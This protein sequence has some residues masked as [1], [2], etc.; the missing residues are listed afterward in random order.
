MTK[1]TEPWPIPTKALGSKGRAA[2]EAILAFLQ[3]KNLTDHGGGGKFYGP[4]EWENR[5]E[6]YGLGALLIVTHD[7][8]DHAPA[9]NWDYE[10]YDLVEDLRLALQKIGVYVEQCTSWYSAIYPIRP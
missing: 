2:A 7:G 1:T 9:F 6:S 8:G 3:E 5:G 10:A 4:E